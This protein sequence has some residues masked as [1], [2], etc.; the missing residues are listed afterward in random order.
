MLNAETLKKIA[1]VLNLEV[2]DLTA[3][4]KSEQEE[5]L[6]VPVVFTQADYDQFG[7]NRFDEGKAAMSEI[8]TKDLKTK[9]PEVSFTGK[10]LDNWIEAYADHKAA[11]KLEEAKINPDER[12]KALEEDKKTL[13]QK[14]TTAEETAAN[15]TK[16]FEQ[17]MFQVETRN[18]ILSL[19]PDNTVIPKEDLVDLFLNRHRVTKEENGISV[20]K[21]SEQLKD[22]QLNLMPL[23]DVVSS[24]SEGY[25]KK[26]GMG[27]G[28]AGGGFT[29]RFTKM[30]QFVDYCKEHNLEP[31]GQEAQNLLLEKK[32]AN[33][34]YKS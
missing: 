3:K 15:A 7:K 16:D 4:I 26:E 13:Q 11:K 8:V 34:D 28:N 27:G 33:F 22:K 1:G 14:L 29:G 23:K 17:R 21:G 19:I 32:E 12:V 5:T 10:N 9:H 20:Y 18:Q 24:F 30:S 2:S 31:M 25:I 6:E